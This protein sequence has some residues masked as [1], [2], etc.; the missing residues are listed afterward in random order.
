MKGANEYKVA[1][2]T[3]DFLEGARFN[4]SSINNLTSS[5]SKHPFSNGILS[6]TFRPNGSDWRAPPVKP[7]DAQL[8]DSLRFKY[9]NEQLKLMT[10]D[11][12]IKTYL[13][14]RQ[15]IHRNLILVSD[16]AVSNSSSVI[17][18][19]DS[20]PLYYPTNWMCR[21]RNGVVNAWMLDVTDP[22]CIP[23]L[24]SASSED[25]AVGAYAEQ[26]PTG[27]LKVGRH[28]ISRCYVETVPSSCKL[29]YEPKLFAVVIAVNA[30]KAI[31]MITTLLQYKRPALVNIGDALASF[32]QEHDKT[33]QGMCLATAAEFTSTSWD[34]QPRGYLEKMRALKRSTGA[35]RQQ[36]ITTITMSVY[37][38]SHR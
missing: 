18:L 20:A 21:Y 37:H 3:P 34:I 17:W 14:N 29:V 33:T 11:E 27:N 31:A 16:E 24:K 23:G 25:W 26:L 19:E 12:C 1:V 36:W 9:H 6:F 35:S 5:S 8:L 13:V 30:V 4:L 22:D 28:R 7:E 10:N 32:L 15:V 2:V 38:L